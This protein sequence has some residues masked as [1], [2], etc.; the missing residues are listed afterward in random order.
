L[1]GDLCGVE[2]KLVLEL[3]HAQD[4]LVVVT[5]RQTLSG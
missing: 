3:L 1:K 4:L 2:D 5:I